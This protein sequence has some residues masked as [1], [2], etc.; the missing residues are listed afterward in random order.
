MHKRIFFTLRILLLVIVRNCFCK[1]VLVVTDSSEG[2]RCH[3]DETECDIVCY[4]CNFYFH[5]PNTTN[6]LSCNITCIGT[7][8]CNAVDVYS[9]YCE[10]VLITASGGF[11]AGQMIIYAPTGTNAS[12]TLVYDWGSQAFDDTKILPSPLGGITKS[13]TLLCNDTSDNDQCINM[14]INAT[15]TQKLNIICQNAAA[16][17][18]MTVYCPNSNLFNNLNITNT[19]CLIDCST[20]YVEGLWFLTD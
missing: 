13:I 5:C 9:Y 1:Q 14:I 16:C 17:S 8:S 4:S 15:T 2:V 12:L 7:I 10:N 11:T 3:A 20:L 19:E 18:D 6:C